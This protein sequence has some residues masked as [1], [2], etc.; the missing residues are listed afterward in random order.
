M[1]PRSIYNAIK[2]KPKFVSMQISPLLRPH[3]H[4]ALVEKLHT[5]T[6]MRQTIKTWLKAG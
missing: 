4:E 5:Y 6:A 1:M 2:S 3:S